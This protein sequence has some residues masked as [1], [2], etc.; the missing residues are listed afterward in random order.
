MDEYVNPK[1]GLCGMFLTN[2]LDYTLSLKN[3]N[4][5]KK[6]KFNSQRTIL[7]IFPYLS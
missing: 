2:A 6:S 1:F 5:S 4:L 3:L 7:M